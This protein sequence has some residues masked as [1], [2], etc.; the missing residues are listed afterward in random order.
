MSLYGPLTAE[1]GSG[2]WGTPANSTG[3]ASWQRYRSDVAHRRPTKLCTM[4]GRLLGWYI[5]YIFSG[6]LTL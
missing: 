1:M 6:A 2:V 5:I 4:L 3:F